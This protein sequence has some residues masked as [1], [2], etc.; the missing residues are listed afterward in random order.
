MNQYMYMIYTKKEIAIFKCYSPEKLIA[1]NIYQCF[2]KPVR[3]TCTGLRSTICTPKTS[4]GTVLSAACRVCLKQGD[5]VS[6]TRHIVGW[7][8]NL[9]GGL[10]SAQPLF[11]DA[12]RACVR[13]IFL[14]GNLLIVV[15]TC[16][17]FCPCFW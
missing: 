2:S 8:V 13:V 14:R 9:L 16:I 5:N 15:T 3:R 4:T 10:P 11:L 12:Y 17:L 1:L 7:R 6:C